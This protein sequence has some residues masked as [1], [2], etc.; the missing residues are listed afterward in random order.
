MIMCVSDELLFTRL[1][2][3]IF[4]YSPGYMKPGNVLNHRTFLDADG[5]GFNIKND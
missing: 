1:I 4:N 2:D 5:D 3:S